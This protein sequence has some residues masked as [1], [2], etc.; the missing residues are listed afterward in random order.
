MFICPECQN[1]K[2]D[3]VDKC[4]HCDW[5]IETI[6]GIPVCLSK[7]D[8]NNSMMQ[9]YIENYETLSEQ[10]LSNN[11]QALKYQQVQTNKLFSYIEELVDKSVCEIG[12]GRGLLFDKLIQRKPRELFGIDVSIQF[13]KRYAN[14]TTKAVNSILANAENLPFAKHFDVIVASDILEH[15]INPGDFLYSVN[16][17]LTENGK[18]IVRV[19]FDENLMQY[20][21]KLGCEYKFAHL[22]C[23]SRKT[24][25]TN[26]DCAGF[27]ITKF[28]YD[29]FWRY[30]TR[31]I[32]QRRKQLMSYL[33][34]FYDKYYPNDLDI[35]NIHNSL[36]CVLMK[37]AEITAVCEKIGDL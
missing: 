1:V 19:P 22:R 4:N 7:S 8:K 15:V 36:G 37:P 31:K 6:D 24:L 12:I 27:R 34:S 23:F 11:L 14:Q 3:L 21:R 5:S 35:A 29:G 30:K 20:S 16:R 18:F 25:R 26:L 2:Q 13:L 9:S 17:A 28:Y 10:E 32:F 33:N